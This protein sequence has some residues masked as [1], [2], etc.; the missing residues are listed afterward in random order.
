MFNFLQ[1]C[2][3]RFLIFLLEILIPACDSCG[4]TFCMMYAACKSLSH[5]WLF[6]TTW[7]AALQISLFFTVYQSLLKLM[8]IESVMPS[9]LGPDVC[10]CWPISLNVAMS[11]LSCLWLSWFPQFLSF[12]R[13]CNTIS[14][15]FY[16]RDFPGDKDSTCP[17][18]RVRHKWGTELNWTVLGLQVRALL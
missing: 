2:G 12:S 11:S 5:V 15:W 10:I 13:H 16:F 6:V 17:C 7:T 1:S 9:W 3:L 4:P 18:I 14:R 8:Y